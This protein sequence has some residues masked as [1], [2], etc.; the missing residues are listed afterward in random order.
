MKLSILLVLAFLACISCNNQ[1]KEQGLPDGY[2]SYMYMNDSSG[3]N[4]DSIMSDRMGV[5]VYQYGEKLFDEENQILYFSGY[6]NFHYPD[7]QSKKTGNYA[8]N[9]KEGVIIN[10]YVDATKSERRV[11]DGDNP[12]TYV[13]GVGRDFGVRLYTEYDD[14]LKNKTALFLMDTSS[15]NI[16]FL[17][18]EDQEE[19]SSIE[20]R[21]RNIIMASGVPN[22]KTTLEA[23]KDKKLPN[24]ALFKVANGD[25]TSQIHIKME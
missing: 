22:Y 18:E 20:L 23:S 13:N 12:K 7:K 17:V 10:S 25:G 1:I 3:I 5:P 21:K 11:E 8:Y 15:Q 14:E 24:G 19:L 6:L 9:L 16:K 2:N 4:F